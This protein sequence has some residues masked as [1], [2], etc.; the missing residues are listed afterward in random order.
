MAAGFA[1]GRGIR[2]EPC[3]LDASSSRSNGLRATRALQSVTSFLDLIVLQVSELVIRFTCFPHESQL[4][5]GVD[6]QPARRPAATHPSDRS[7][8][9]T[10]AAC[11]PCYHFV[12]ALA[13]ILCNPWQLHTS[14]Q[15]NSLPVRAK[16]CLWIRPGWLVT[17]YW[18]W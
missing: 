17:I 18:C 8:R 16:R 11:T 5:G 2:T 9:A 3:R 12:H 1:F 15:S 14:R 4:T 10:P 7:G 13:R 6:S